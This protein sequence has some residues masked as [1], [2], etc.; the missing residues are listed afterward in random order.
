MFSRI[1]NIYET[2]YI[3]D[4]GFGSFLQTY[5]DGNFEKFMNI[6]LLFLFRLHTSGTTK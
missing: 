2:S 5:S 3:Y 1:Y 4:N 6:L